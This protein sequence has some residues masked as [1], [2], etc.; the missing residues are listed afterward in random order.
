MRTAVFCA[1]FL[2]YQLGAAHAESVGEPASAP[3]VV[4]TPVATDETPAAPTTEPAPPKADK[5]VGMSL[6]GLL[7]KEVVTS[8]RVRQKLSKSHSSITVITAEEIRQLP[9][10]DLME[11]LRFLVPGLEAEFQLEGHSE[12]LIGARGLKGNVFSKRLLFLLDGRP[13]NYPIDGDFDL[14]LRCSLN[15]VRQIE[16]IRGPGSS[17][18]GANAFLGV[19]NII[20][21]P[22]EDS[23]DGGSVTARY[24]QYGN[25][26]ASGTANVKVLGDV[27][28]FVSH[29]QMGATELGISREFYH[30][31]STVTDYREGYDDRDTKISVEYKGLT[32]RAGAFANHFDSP[33]RGLYANDPANPYFTWTYRE[34]NS[35]GSLAYEHSLHRNLNVSLLGYLS[36]TQKDDL[37]SPPQGSARPWVSP[38]YVFKDYESTENAG[39]VNGQLAYTPT[40]SV[41]LLVGGDFVRLASDA[42]FD[43][44]YLNGQSTHQGAVFAEGNYEPFPWLDLVAGGRYDRH[45]QYDPQVSPRF[46]AMGKF[47]DSKASL[48]LSYG[49]A[50]RA[51]NFAEFAPTKAAYPD[52]VLQPEKIHSVELAAS[53]QA[54]I[55]KVTATLF[56]AHMTDTIDYIYQKGKGITFRNLAGT[57]KSRGVELEVNALV[58]RHV[59]LW[60]YYTYDDTSS[61][62]PGDK[63]AGWL[64]FA[65]HHKG[66]LGA[67][68]LFAKFDATLAS[69]WV[70]QQRNN[71]WAEVGQPPTPAYI[72]FFARANYRVTSKLTFGV[73]VKNLFNTAYFDKAGTKITATGAPTPEQ[74]P[75][76]RDEYYPPRTI[77]A[78]MR[79]SF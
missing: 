14:E 15:G 12:M 25:H 57:Q 45:S 42:K 5:Y 27:K 22:P 54:P 37:Y 79:L 17:L 46:S 63:Y 20:T 64:I 76:W 49:S 56:D 21:G 60:S 72:A 55:V 39:G 69:Y 58:A 41:R 6:E 78:D 74:T 16:I 3:S 51:P 53:Y 29:E 44:P 36:K 26:E 47:L 71:K 28:V 61:D 10:T 23:Q 30:L 40:E 18:Y 35:F 66:Q 1:V 62:I 70:G 13:L 19:V 43:R 32:L 24:G 34:K 67:S 31:P 52:L 48:R 11:L 9:A 59:R 33:G 73:T 7:N 38:S 68:L 8:G 50:F 2:A 77:L 4:P 65:P 75:D